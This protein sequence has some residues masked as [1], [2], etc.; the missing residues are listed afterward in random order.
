MRPSL[1]IQVV[2]RLLRAPEPSWWRVDPTREPLKGAR[3]SLGG[4]SLHGVEVA[5]KREPGG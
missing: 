4:N 1:I 2:H 5:L 3:K